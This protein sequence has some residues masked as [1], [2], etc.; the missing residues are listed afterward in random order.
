MVRRAV[1]RQMNDIA[2]RSDAK[3][4][5]NQVA[6]SAHAKCASTARPASGVTRTAAAALNPLKYAATAVPA[7]AQ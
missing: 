3:K 2:R 5:K 4:T 6:R 7:P 1:V